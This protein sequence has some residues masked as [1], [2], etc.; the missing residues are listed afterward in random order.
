M[1][2]AY[3]ISVDPEEGDVNAEELRQDHHQRGKQ[4][5]QRD[6]LCGQFFHN[7]KHLPFICITITK[8]T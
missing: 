7:K 5:N 2:E 8:T 4:C 1:S 3:A 6:L